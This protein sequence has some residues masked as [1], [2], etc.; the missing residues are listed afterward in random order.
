MLQ[1]GE[2]S[3]QEACVIAGYTSPAN[4]STA[5]R[6]QFGIS[7]REMFKNNLHVLLLYKRMISYFIQVL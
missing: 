3:I 2:A 4:F 5:F 7:P 6:R 1:S